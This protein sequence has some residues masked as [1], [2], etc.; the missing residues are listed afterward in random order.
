MYTSN[1]GMQERDISDI[2]EAMK[3]EDKEKKGRKKSERWRNKLDLKQRIVAGGSSQQQD[4]YLD[5]S[6]ITADTSMLP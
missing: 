4:S 1:S 3:I 6:I 5:L 2:L